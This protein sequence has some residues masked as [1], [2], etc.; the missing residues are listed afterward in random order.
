MRVGTKRDNENDND[1]VVTAF[2]L[3]CGNNDVNKIKKTAIIILGTCYH[4]SN[5]FFNSYANLFAIAH[6]CKKVK[7][8]VR[9]TALKA[10]HLVSWKWNKQKNEHEQNDITSICVVWRAV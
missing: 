5:S 7:N 8:D 4:L 1:I 2:F 3:L 10:H 9:K 6:S